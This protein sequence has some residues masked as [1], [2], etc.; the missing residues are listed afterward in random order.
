MCNVYTL[1]VYV[2]PVDPYFS[3]PSS[4]CDVFGLCKHKKKTANK[5]NAM[6]EKHPVTCVCAR[7]FW[8]HF[9][10]TLHSIGLMTN[11]NTSKWLLIVREYNAHLSALCLL[12]ITF[13]MKTFWSMLHTHT[14]S[15]LSVF[16]YVYFESCRQLCRSSST[17]GKV[18]IQ[19]IHWCVC[20]SRE[21]RLF[22]KFTHSAF[23]WFRESDDE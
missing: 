21:C 12:L 19:R 8:I 10:N 18:L 5:R 13:L 16:A 1:D 20:I 4:S 3:A 23:V 9:L 7:A 17:D 15:A 14:V 6:N 11:H 2:L 22:N